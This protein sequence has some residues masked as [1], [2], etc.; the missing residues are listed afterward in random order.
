MLSLRS[1][2]RLWPKPHCR[3]HH[4]DG[5]PRQRAE[6]GPS[7]DIHSGP[8]RSYSQPG[9]FAKAVKRVLGLTNS[10]EKPMEGW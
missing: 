4:A 8:M 10:N 9:Y 7:P 6:H 5:I 3:P 2:G 1:L